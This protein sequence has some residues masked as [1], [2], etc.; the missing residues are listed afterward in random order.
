[1]RTHTVAGEQ[2]VQREKGLQLQNVS[3]LKLLVVCAGEG[4]AER[5]ACNTPK[6]LAGIV[7]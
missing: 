5:R 6:I 4:R 1:M 2:D 7:V 3:G